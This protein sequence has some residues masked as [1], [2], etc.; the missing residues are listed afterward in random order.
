MAP[1]ILFLKVP[2]AKTAK[3]RFHPDL[4]TPYLEAEVKRLVGL[5]AAQQQEIEES[6]YHWIT[7]ADPEGNEFDVVEVGT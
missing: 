7:L 2:E 4:V 1:D 5:G 6:G 3:N